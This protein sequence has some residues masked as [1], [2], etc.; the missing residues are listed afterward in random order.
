LEIG[1][2][3]S[4]FSDDW[5]IEGARS[6]RARSQA[7]SFAISLLAHAVAIALIVYFAPALARPH[8]DW[9]LAYLV[10][11]R[12]GS[13]GRSARAGRDPSTPIHS[14]VGP[15]LIPAPRSSHKRGHAST[16]VTRTD[17]EYEIKAPDAE[18]AS[19][20]ST[21]PAVSPRATKADSHGAESSSGPS[22]AP[23]TNAPP[24]GAGGDSAAASGSTDGAGDGDG[25][26][27]AHADYGKNPPPIYPAIAR[28]HAQ[29]GTV[30]L[31]VLVAIDGVV[32]RAEIAESSG[33]DAL[34]EAAL[35]TVRRRWRFVPARRSGLPVDSWVLVPIRFALT[36]ANAA[37]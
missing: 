11:V 18:V 20:K 12:D 36:E 2:D 25:S 10:E 35:E 5:S 1:R 13:S 21:A 7:V 8:S 30:T 37:R 23:S 3:K 28:R 14:E 15:L 29:Q 27:V 34:D 4:Q 31:R 17:H 24:T 26:S 9:V 33:F 32:A 16:H 6:Q 19:L 22:N